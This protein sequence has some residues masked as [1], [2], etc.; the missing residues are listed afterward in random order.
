MK[1]VPEWRSKSRD[2]SRKN[3][4]IKSALIAILS[5]AGGT[6]THADDHAK[7]SA[8]DLLIED[9]LPLYQ[10]KK[11]VANAL[12]VVEETKSRDADLVGSDRD[13]ETLKIGEFESNEDFL[14]RQKAASERRARL[15]AE[16]RLA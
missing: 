2:Q 1:L 10:S 13:Q 16:R 4:V 3:P 15:N 9:V 6:A 5:F 11:S 14:A 7:N 12:K 8:Y